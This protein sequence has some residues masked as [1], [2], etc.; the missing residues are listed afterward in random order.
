MN[1]V[2]GD[3]SHLIRG[4]VL[5]IR[6]SIAWRLGVPVAPLDNLTKDG[7]L[8]WQV[9]VRMTLKRHRR[10]PDLTPTSV[11]AWLESRSLDYRPTRGAA[12]ETIESMRWSLGA[13]EDELLAMSTESFVDCWV[14]NLESVAAITRPSNA[15]HGVSLLAGEALQHLEQRPGTER[16][17]RSLR[18][19][20]DPEFR[21][22][23]V[24]LG[25]TSPRLDLS[26]VNRSDW[27][28]VLT[29]VRPSVQVEEHT[30]RAL[31]APIA[32]RS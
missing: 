4:L 23:R 26:L 32:A 2:L 5:G 31:S 8:G 20:D 1:H 7:C 15:G 13:L 27:L 19:F 17:Q 25:P 10:D 3:T 9:G 18:P 6:P 16:L 30:G 21:S 24:S 22:R 11:L 14:R 12:F 28:E 29:G